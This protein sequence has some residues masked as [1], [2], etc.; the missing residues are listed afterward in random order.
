VSTRAVFPEL[1]TARADQFDE[2]GWRVTE[3][4]A[5]RGHASCDFAERVLEVP[6]GTSAVDR[7]IRA[8]ELMHVRVSPHDVNP[9]AVHTDIVPR[10]LECAEEYR[11][12]ELLGRLGFDLAALG[13]GSETASGHR[14]AQADAWAEAVYFYV[15][16]LGTG[17]EGAFLRGVRRVRSPWVKPLGVLR[18]R[19]VALVS[20]LATVDVGST[21]RPAGEI[22]ALPRGFELVSV[23]VAR[24][25][26]DV[27]AAAVPESADQLRQL[28][29]SLEPGGRRAPTGRFAPLVFDATLSYEAVA[30]RALARRHRPDVS[31][32][33]MAYPNR[34]LT[35]PH[36]R[37]FARPR[38]AVGGIVVVDQSGSMD[39]DPG[40]L[41]RLLA[42]TPGATVVGYSHRPGDPG[43]TANAWLIADAG[44][45]V[46]E[47]PTGNVG[48]GVDGPVLGWAL[49]RRRRGDPVLWVTDGQVTDSNDHPS[50]ALSAHCAALVARHRIRLVRTLA[51][52]ADALAGHRI[53][54]EPVRQFGRVGRALVESGAVTG[55]P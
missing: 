26:M 20:G 2:R 18:R 22:D 46:R 5:L 37:A 6:Y 31:G 44:R 21:E 11:V 47:L 33:A 43:V 34:L 25:M 24:L 45:R 39:L 30:R 10:A 36:R 8:H 54:S 15:A 49:A 16:T 29:R 42:R 7:V 53:P 12:N 9:L 38:R 27:A 50:T 28:R 14:L 23:P 19:I 1:V 41:D 3:G 40:D 55:P 4:W 48:N 17:A 35:D 51:E 13:D 52:A 32:T